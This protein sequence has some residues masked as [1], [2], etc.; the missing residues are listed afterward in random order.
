MGIDW[1][2]ILGAEGED[3]AYA[4]DDSIPDDDWDDEPETFE[5]DD[6]RELDDEWEIDNEWE[7]EGS[8]ESEETTENQSEEAP[9]PS[10]SEIEFPDDLGFGYDDESP[11][12]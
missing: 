10:I 3:M 5:Q 4:Y 8:P 12:E 9:Q 7:I 6:E 11:I 1:E 2:E